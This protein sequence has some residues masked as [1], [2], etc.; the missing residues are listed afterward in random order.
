MFGTAIPGVKEDRRRRPRAAEGALI[1]HI[2][3]DPSRGGLALRENRNCRVVAVHAL[4]RKDVRADA[5]IERAK[6][7]RTAANLVGQG[8]DAES[9][10]RNSWVS[11][12]SAD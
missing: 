5:V 9:P 2:D 4:A 1:A 6:E 3:P 11:G 12:Q 7:C 8:R 10:V